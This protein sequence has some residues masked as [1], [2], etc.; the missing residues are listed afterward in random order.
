MRKVRNPAKKR[1]ERLRG[2]R[3]G[4]I[5]LQGGEHFRSE[6]AGERH[7]GDVKRAQNDSLRA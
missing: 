3:K 4:G 5:V 6:G 7:G 1:L 2:G